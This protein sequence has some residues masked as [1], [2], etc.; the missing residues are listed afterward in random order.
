MSTNLIGALYSLI[1]F[2]LFAIMDV[3]N[4]F[5]LQIGNIAFF[6]FLVYLDIS[7]LI[8]LLL[9]GFVYYKFAFFKPNKPLFT[10]MRAV[11]SVVN[12]LV[13]L[14]AV[15]H[16]PL[17]IFYSLTFLTPFVAI[18]L[19]VCF[20]KEEIN[21][22]KLSFLL[23]GFLG[24][25]LVI[26][27]PSSF[28][29]NHISYFGLL[30]AFLVAVTNAINGIIVRK[31]M[32][33]SN[34]FTIAFYNILLS[35]LIG[36]I[37]ISL[38]YNQPLLDIKFTQLTLISLAGI[39]AGLGMVFSMWSFQK[40]KV[41]NITHFQYTQII[42]GIVFGYFIFKDVPNIFSIIGAIIII[43]SNIMITKKTAL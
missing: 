32:P 26:I 27:H 40:A 2:T 23:L 18:I 31:Y 25:L 17:Y 6:V 43:I 19:A 20:L 15:S 10:G 14:Y 22:Y 12:T 9:C 33:T 42:F 1:A 4:K 37:Y 34:T 5:I 29:A 7:I 35:L 3:I 39:T 30:C 21:L 24:V 8:F 13:S 41:I 16:L 38:H 11:I 28:A 36:L